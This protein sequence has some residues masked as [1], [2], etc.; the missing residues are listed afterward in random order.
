MAVT[1]VSALHWCF[2][3]IP[4]SLEFWYQHAMVVLQYCSLVCLS[5]YAVPSFSRTVVGSESNHI[6]CTHR[7]KPAPGSS[8]DKSEQAE[9]QQLLSPAPVQ[10]ASQ[11]S[12]T[13]GKHKE[14][15]LRL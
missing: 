11:G 2:F 4:R 8:L 5:M 1:D 12:G 15:V 6:V 7:P 13:L 14:E 9:S 3:S 10:G